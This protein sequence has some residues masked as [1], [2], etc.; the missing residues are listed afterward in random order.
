M[1]GHDKKP[2][3]AIFD[4]YTVLSTHGDVPRGRTND[5][6][7]PFINSANT[8]LGLG[9]FPS[10]VEASLTGSSGFDGFNVR[11]VRGARFGGADDVFCEGAGSCGFAGG[12]GNTVGGD[13]EEVELQ[14]S[15]PIVPSNV[16]VVD[17]K[18]TK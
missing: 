16:R 8:R 10:G 18:S 1:Q 14:G 5:S 12:S 2:I 4:L 3:R 11:D 9:A 7:C 17:S 6:A 13:C 15:H